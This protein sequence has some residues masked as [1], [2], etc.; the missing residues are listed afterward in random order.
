MLA[1]LVMIATFAEPRPP[2]RWSPEVFDRARR[3]GRFVLLDLGAGWCHWCHVM[4]TTTYRDLAVRERIER[5]FVLVAVDQDSDPELADRYQDYGWPATIVFAPDGSEIV[6]RRGY[7]PPE[8]MVSLLDAIVA[9]PTPGPSIPPERTPRPGVRGGFS[10]TERDAIEQQALERYDTRF[11]GFGDGHKF[12]PAFEIEFAIQ[13]AIEGDPRW[14]PIARRT[15]YENLRLIDPV[16]GGVYQYSDQ[17]DWKSPHHEKIMSFQADDLRLYALAYS[18]FQDPR[19]RTAARSIASYL[20]STLSSPDGAF[21]AS[22]DADSPRIDRHRYAQNTGW[23]AEGLVSWFRATGDRGALLRAIRGVEW[24][25]R[26]RKTPQGFDHEA[27]ER[28][29]LVDTLAMAQAELALAVA[30][31]ERRWLDEADQ[32]LTMIEDRFRDQ[33]GFFSSAPGPEAIGVFQQPVH[34]VDQ[35]IGVARAAALLFRLTLKARHRDAAEHALAFLST[36]EVASSR[37]LFLGALLAEVELDPRGSPVHLVVLG[38]PKDPRTEALDRAGVSLPVRMIELERR[39]G[40]EP[41]VLACTPGACSTPISDPTRVRD[42]V[43]G[44][45]RRSSARHL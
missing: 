26:E 41:R 21:Y 45:M 33:V 6:R 31:G 7:I 11:G 22:Q 4:E 32:A 34:D 43:E 24:A 13:R 8:R 38:P 23:A 19:Y 44:L 12:L 5:S 25:L 42:T 40:G 2:A 15:L 28:K 39:E 29:Y 20:Q 10:Q 27:G 3:E 30:T 9:D 35:N 16:D 36:P 37:F 14:A 18:A 17:P 1:A